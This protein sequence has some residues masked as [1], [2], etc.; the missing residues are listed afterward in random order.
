[1]ASIEEKKMK[2]VKKIKAEK[3][4]EKYYLMLTSG[5]QKGPFH[6]WHDGM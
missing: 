3:N 6:P 4:S 5:Q 2:K 1:M